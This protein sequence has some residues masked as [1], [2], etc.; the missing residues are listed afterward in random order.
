MSRT[1]SASHPVL[2]FLLDRYNIKNDAEL[3]RLLGFDAPYI[4]K[5]RNGVLPRTPAMALAIHEVFEISFAELR[6][7]SA[8]FVGVAAPTGVAA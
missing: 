7:L 6:N 1:P 2:D 3:C 5:V 4:S 8:D